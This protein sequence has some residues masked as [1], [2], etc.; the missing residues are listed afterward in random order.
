MN[1]NKNTSLYPIVHFYDKAV[2][3]V[4][5]HKHLGMVIDLKLGCEDHVKSV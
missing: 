1:R 3:S 5:I 2:N 4:K